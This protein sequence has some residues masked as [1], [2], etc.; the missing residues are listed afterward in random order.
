[1][2]HEGIISKSATAES[3]L[4]D[5]FDKE[6]LFRLVAEVSNTKTD[7][8]YHIVMP[9][10]LEN[11]GKSLKNNKIPF[12]LDHNKEQKLG[13]SIDGLTEGEDMKMRAIGTFEIPRNWD[14]KVDTNEFIK[15][16]E[17]GALD[18]VSVGIKVKDVT[19]NICEKQVAK[20]IFDFFMGDPK[21]ICMEHKPGRT[22]NKKVSKW[23]LN[24]GVLNEVSCVYAGANFSADIIDW[25]KAFLSQTEIYKDITDNDVENIMPFMPEFSEI[26]KSHPGII[27]TQE[28]SFPDIFNLKSPTPSGGKNVDFEKELAKLTGQSSAFIKDLP[29]DPLQAMKKVVDECRIAKDEKADLETKVSEL[30]AKADKFDEHYEEKVKKA[31]E[32]GVIA[33]GDAFDKDKW[34]QILKGYNDLSLVDIHLQQWTE[35][36]DGELPPEQGQQTK[37][38]KPNSS[39]SSS[40]ESDNNWYDWRD[41]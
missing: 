6:N 32:Q 36:A 40:D 23:H 30:Q 35:E 24:D 38:S 8:H 1:M 41:Y 3:N 29:D 10:F 25:T 13:K 7:S 11:M 27:P 16:V 39:S 21:K 12:L 37:K 9:K 22:Y 31:I 15:G 33:K 17:N 4:S 34:E 2:L 19:C 5:G 26:A 14:L 28:Y 18:S 20:S